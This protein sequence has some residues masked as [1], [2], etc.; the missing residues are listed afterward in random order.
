MIKKATGLAVALLVAYNM[1]VSQFTRPWFFPAPNMF[2]NNRICAQELIFGQRRCDVIVVGTSMTRTLVDALPE[3]WCNMG[4]NGLSSLD[5]LEIVS[6]A[7]MKPSLILV[8]VNVM[9][10]LLNTEFVESLFVPGLGFLR[11]RLPALQARYEPASF[12][13]GCWR[14][15]RGY[16]QWRH[17]GRNAKKKTH[18]DDSE[19]RGQSARHAN[20]ASM[21]IQQGIVKRQTLPDRLI[22]EQYVARLKAHVDILMA[23]GISVILFELP[24]HESLFHSPA[25]NYERQV[26]REMIPG[27]A[28]IYL[29]TPECRM[30]QTSDGSHL[31]APSA[32]RYC[33]Y[34][35]PA[36]N[37]ILSGRSF[38]SE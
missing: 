11:E 24:E 37:R 2:H 1:F 25:R 30:Y 32:A 3:N 26:L 22:V 33:Q 8:E 35:V 9:D 4:L 20:F 13:L 6:R 16:R 28:Y 17:E 34:L 12:A 15:A 29:P 18:T 36:V 31:D 7:G 27:S 10:R 21:F 23:A 14:V 5:G 19:S 38:S